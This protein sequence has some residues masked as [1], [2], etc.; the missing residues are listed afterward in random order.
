MFYRE[1]APKECSGAP[2][3]SFFWFRFGLL[4]C[5]LNTSCEIERI[6]PLPNGK[7][8]FSSDAIVGGTVT[9]GDKAV[10]TLLTLVPGRGYFSYCSGT[11][12]AP[13]TV[14]TAAHC[15]NAQGPN[16][17]YFV[18]VADTADVRYQTVRVAEQFAHPD[19]ANTVSSPH[20]FGIL[21]LATPIL[22]VEPIPLNEQPLSQSDI[23]LNI[24]H[25][26]FGTTSGADL[27]GG[28]KRQVVTK[29]RTIVQRQ[30][31]H[32]LPDKGTCHGDSGGPG[33]MQL[34]GQASETVVGVVSYGDANCQFMSWDGRVDTD[35]TWMRTTMA[36]WEIATCDLDGVC[37][38]G[39]TPVDQDCACKKDGTCNIACA[40]LITDFDCPRSCF[41]DG[42]CATQGC[43][44]PD[45]DCLAEGALCAS[46]PL[47][48]PGQRCVT[49]P[50]HTNT[51]CSRPC[52]ADSA[53]LNGF[54]CL[55]GTC[56]YPQRPEKKLYDLCTAASDFCRD[57]ICTGPA[58]GFTR[59]VKTCIIT[60]DCESGSDCV[61]GANSE[62][63]CKP[64][65]VKF[66][67]I[68][69]PAA[70][71]EVSGPVAQTGCTCQ[72]QSWSSVWGLGLV[73]VL[74]RRRRNLASPGWK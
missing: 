30:L 64:F 45:V 51:Y 13:R 29:L 68:K 1:N 44:K 38:P 39:C 58:D 25:V 57:T 60:S 9:T 50:Q 62:R 2:M 11:L 71:T 33:F 37:L 28:V 69:L 41:A 15:I 23:G 40:D 8:D 6:V 46:K 56:G 18:A 72:S 7:L 67:N 61:S 19:Y 66:N 59:C 12:I 3:S 47:V 4:L 53:C 48:C 63:Y 26:G 74:W 20:D 10:L 70:P 14:L 17:E 22:N 5:L 34:S 35:V 21:H 52:T 43:L 31:E 36:Q 27:G 32:G 49:D 16:A 73:V 65:N 55:S 54:V 42:V 24:R